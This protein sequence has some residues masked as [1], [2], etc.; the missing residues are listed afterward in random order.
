MSNKLQV[1]ANQPA[2]KSMICDPTKEPISYIDVL[3]EMGMAG[4]QVQAKQLVD[5]TFVILRAKQFD[6]S[7][8]DDAHAYFCTI[9]P[10]DEAEPYT[11][12]L[13]GQAVVEVLD[14]FV[15]YGSDQPLKVTLRYAE[16]QGKF[17]GYYFFE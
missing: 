6:S 8:Q 4:V 9:K 14:A 5:K 7:F 16:G 15:A 10:L 1:T 13:G 17:S 3:R 12:V 11:V 2:R